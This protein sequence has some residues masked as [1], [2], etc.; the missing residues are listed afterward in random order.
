[1]KRKSGSMKNESTGTVF[2][3]S[4][5]QELF[6]MG[7]NQGK[8]HGKGEK[9]LSWVEALI[10]ASMMDVHRGKKGKS[11]DLRVTGGRNSAEKSR[12]S[13]LYTKER[14]WSARGEKKRIRFENEAPYDIPRVASGLKDAFMNKFRK[15]FT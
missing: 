4:H 8:G 2:K 12:R 6:H 3:V 1:V 7:V 9:L 5:E 13:W 14:G 10:K 15:D 11:D